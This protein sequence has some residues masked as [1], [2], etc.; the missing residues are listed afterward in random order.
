MAKLIVYRGPSMPG[1][2]KYVDLSLSLK[3]AHLLKDLIAL[4]R[5]PNGSM[6]DGIA[7]QLA[8]LPALSE[9]ERSTTG[10]LIEGGPVKCAAPGCVGHQYGQ[11][12]HPGFDVATSTT[13]HG[14][15][16]SDSSHD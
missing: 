9:V 5:A 12:L 15:V 7:E 1:P 6:Y 11:G 2:V 16:G 14:C 8:Q 4:K 10:D 3:E 13:Q